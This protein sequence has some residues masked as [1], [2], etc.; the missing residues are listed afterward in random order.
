MRA[1]GS[2]KGRKSRVR[3]PQA[4]CTCA[5]IGRHGPQQ[6]PAPSWVISLLDASLEEI[7]ALLMVV[8]K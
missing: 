6:C 8:K 4:L 3:G 1:A 2:W 7:E 5:V